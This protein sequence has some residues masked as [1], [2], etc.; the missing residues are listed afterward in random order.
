MPKKVLIILGHPNSRSFC[1]ALAKAYAEGARQSGAEVKELYLGELKF[2]PILHYGY[3]KN[4]ELEPDLK[5]A[6]HDIKWAN[7]L[8]FV[9]PTWWG[10]M[11]ALLKGFIERTFLPGF[12]F[13]Y[14]PGT[15]YWVKK[16]SGKTAHVIVTMDTPK[17]YYRIILEAAGHHIIRKAIL[18]FCG[19][20]HCEI[21]E[22]GP[23]I[24]STKEKRE[25][26]LE[27]VRKKAS[28]L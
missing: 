24:T 11:P 18:E 26:W 19:I 22:Y 25:K 4:M 16:L 14:K 9:Y 3:A 6:Q 1:A 12:A 15:R 8:V 13:S 27:E 28:K 21:M 2:D 23:I 7:H 5:K 20:H 10:T 17:W